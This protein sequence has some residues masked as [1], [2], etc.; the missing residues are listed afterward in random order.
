MA[1]RRRNL[2]EVKDNA[3]DDY[4]A[5]RHTPQC[6]SYSIRPLHPRDSGENDDFCDPLYMY[7]SLL[8]SIK[9]GGG[10]PLWGTWETLLNLSYGVI[11]VHD[12]RHTQLLF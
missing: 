12:H 11:Y 8:V 7:P 5:R 3:Q 2:R 6:T 10:L 9:G 1:G 4:H